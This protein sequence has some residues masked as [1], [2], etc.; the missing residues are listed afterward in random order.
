MSSAEKINK[1]LVIGSGTMGHGIVEVAAIAGYKVYMADINDEI[2]K[3]ALEKIKWSIT[4]LYNK[5]SLRE[6]VDSL[7]SRISTVVNVDSEGNFTEEFKNVVKEA[8]MFIEAIPERLDIKQ[9]LFRFIDENRKKDT[10]MA[11]NTSSLPITEIASATSSPELVVGMHFFNPPPLMPLVEIIKGDKTSDATVSTVYEIAKKFGKQPVVVKKD[12]PG[13][14]VNRVLARFLNTACWLAYKGKGSV[15]EIDSSIRYNLGFPMGAFELADYSGIDVFY[16]VNKAITERGF[17]MVH[18]PLFEEKFKSKELGMKSGKGFYEYPK[19]G[20]YVRPQIPKDLANKIDPVLLIAPAV[21]EGAW[22]LENEVASKEDIDKAVMLGLGW[23][24]GLFEFADSYGIDNVNKA[25]RSLKEMIGSEEYNPVKLLVDMESQGLLGRKSSKGFYE[26]KKVEEVSKKTLI[27]RYEKPIAWIVLN[28]PNKLNAISPETIKE[29]YETLD[30]LELNEDV[31]VIILTGSGRAFSAGADVTAFAGITPMQAAIF[32]KKF[33]E[34]T[35]KMQYYAKPIIVAI[36]GYT[37][38]GGLEI[39]MSGDIRIASETALF[40]QPEINLGFIPGAGGTQRL[41]RLVGR[42]QSKTI[43]FTGD[44][45]TAREALGMKLVDRVVPPERLEQ[46]AR[47]LALKIASKPPLA[48]MAAKLSIEQ[49]LESNIW[50]GL[51]LEA[52][53]FGLLFSTED[54]IE[55]V[56]AFLEKRKPSFKGK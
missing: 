42:G 37:L 34:L 31:R 6:S 10:I 33:Q 44:N 12:V 23:P 47:E 48:L 43:I 24:K 18:C 25:L 20:A 3:N 38:G 27:I 9:N 56:T 17:K 5:G 54:V 30:E 19:P 46:E 41:P 35:L 28:R 39:S 13:F 45:I 15:L 40:G 29:L 2:L 14:I 4:K 1:I 51:N 11:T 36:N 21:N 55:G 32:S 26:Y 52:S 22:L 49:G 16:Y 7:M 8:D 53:L 50:A